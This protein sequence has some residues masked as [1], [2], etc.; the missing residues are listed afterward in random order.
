MIIPF[1][2]TGLLGIIWAAVAG[3]G[4]LPQVPGSGTNAASLKFFTAVAGGTNAE[5]AYFDSYASG[6]KEGLTGAMGTWCLRRG[7]TNGNARILGWY[8]GQRAGS[9]AIGW[10]TEIADASREYFQV[11]GKWPSSLREAQPDR[12]RKRED[13]RADLLR[14]TTIESTNDV[15]GR[16]IIY[17]PF[18]ASL[19]YGSVLSYGLD[20]VPGGSGFDLDL[21]VRFDEKK[22]LKYAQSLDPLSEQPPD[23]GQMLSNIMTK[24]IKT[25]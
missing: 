13:M 6:Y 22:N 15:W 1:R 4:P 19:G 3:A 7:A 12:A 20:G 2:L 11:Y 14:R 9:A 8:D 10:L 24:Q 18:D 16:P 25:K 21:E 17:K 5:A 23:F